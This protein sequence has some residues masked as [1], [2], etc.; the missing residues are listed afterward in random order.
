[1]TQQDEIIQYCKN[2]KK[3]V[4]IKE[5][6][7][8]G[9]FMITFPST[10]TSQVPAELFV[11]LIHEEIFVSKNS[12]EGMKVGDVISWFFNLRLKFYDTE[13]ANKK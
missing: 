4:K 13:E 7:G 5:G 12:V 11:D 3:D 2:Y 1:M 9:T 10:C 6:N 8:L